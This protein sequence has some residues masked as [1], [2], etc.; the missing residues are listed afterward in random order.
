MHSLRITLIAPFVAGTLVLTLLL[1]WYTYS[2]SRKAVEDAMLLISEAK[3]AQTL[4]SM[5]IL[6]RS[7]SSTIQNFVADPHVIALFAGDAGD[8]Y[9]KDTTEWLNI[10]ISG[11]EYYRDLL[12]VDKNGVCIASSNPGHVGT[13]YLGQVYVRRALRG[14]FALGEPSVGRVTKRFSASMAGPIDVH[15]EVVGALIML[16]DFPKI[17]DYDSRSS[18][19]EHV[20]FTA[21]LTPEGQFAAH[22]D[23]EF[24]GANAPL[25]PEV[26]GQLAAV[27]ERGG[28]VRYTVKGK[29]YVGYARVERETKWIVLTSGLEKDVYAPAYQ[30]GAVVLGLSLGFLLLIG[31]VVIHFAN[32]ILTHL[33]TLIGYARRVSE[34]DLDLTLD[35]TDRKD[36]LG[37][38]HNALRRLVL[39]LHAMLEETQEASKMKG[40][41]LANMSHEIRTPLNAIIGMTHLTLRENTLT[42]RVHDF[43]NKIQLSAKSLLGLINDILDISKVEANMIELE[44]IPFNLKE[45]LENTLLIH[46]EA[47]TGKGL[48]LRLS[49]GAGTPQ[50]FYGDPLRISQIVNNLVSNAIKFTKQGSVGVRCRL[51]EL[52]PD[53]VDP[54]P[55]LAQEERLNLR[56]SVTDSGIGMSPEVISSLFQPFTQ[57]DASITRQFGGTGLGLAISDRLV[58]LLHGHFDVESEE[59]RGA[60]FSFVM[61]L[62]P[63]PTGESEAQAPSLDEAFEQLQLQGKTILVAED[64]QINQMIMEEL[65]AP[66]GATILMANNGS[67]AVAIAK[68]QRPDLV[69]MD[70]QMPVMDGLDATAQIRTFADSSELP[71]IAVTANAMKED[72][73]KGFASGMNDYITKPIEPK[74]LLDILRDWLR[75]PG[76]TS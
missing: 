22:K 53:M 31:F 70:L 27:G 17:V 28:D 50:F 73:E 69:F 45:T 67:E 3:T 46:Q 52:P 11:N 42:D 54:D 26:Y 24:M 1:S 5:T 7:M 40:Q 72:K 43:V 38:L 76:T 16:N 71:I 63:N 30:T 61:Q 57:A 13:S 36:E 2:S 39:S 44:H 41:F 55:A 59:G 64:N 49:Y 51:E 35:P 48:D 56:V 32:T 29:T 4:N 66:S 75:P 37:V 20:L 6:F 25:F 12:V 23:K 14:R 15:G 21:M 62:E 19:D 10:V 68:S 58:K 60:T 74:R 65:L 9:A 34:G 33:L 47:A 8:G 18:L